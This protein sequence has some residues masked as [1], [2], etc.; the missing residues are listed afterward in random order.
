[1]GVNSKL[2]NKMVKLD[3]VQMVQYL[4][5]HRQ[6]AITKGERERQREEKK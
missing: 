1:M 5:V 2:A 6:K 4:D 3:Q